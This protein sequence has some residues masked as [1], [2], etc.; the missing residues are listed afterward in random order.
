MNVALQRLD[1]DLGVRFGDDSPDQLAVLQF[2]DVLDVPL[3]G[4]HREILPGVR[5]VADERFLNITVDALGSRGRGV[6][7][8][9]EV[10]KGCHDRDREFAAALVGGGGPVVEL[11]EGDRTGALGALHPVLRQDDEGSAEEDNESDPAR[12]H[13][14]SRLNSAPCIIIPGPRR[15]RQPN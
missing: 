15:A 6:L 13:A 14:P 1:I 12:F 3:L 5:R 10:A 7:V 4:E 8:G 2:D 11:V 9:V